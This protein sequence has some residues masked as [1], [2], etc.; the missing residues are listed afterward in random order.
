M[1]SLISGE[2][3]RTELPLSQSWIYAPSDFQVN[4]ESLTKNRNILRAFY[5][6]K[7]V[8]VRPVKLLSIPFRISF[9]R[10]FIVALTCSISSITFKLYQLLVRLSSQLQTLHVG[11]GPH[12]SLSTAQSII[13]TSSPPFRDTAQEY[14]C[15][16]PTL[17]RSHA[18]WH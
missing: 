2:E 15:C 7:S 16:E 4:E 5:A 11:G 8:K 17:V 1:L 9:C 3:Q 14:R 13:D 12:P 18:L 6:R 10:L